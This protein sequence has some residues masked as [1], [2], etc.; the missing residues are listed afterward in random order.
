MLEIDILLEA[1]KAS[2]TYSKI[3]L[4]V[5]KKELEGKRRSMY[6]F[7]WP[8]NLIILEKENEALFRKIKMQTKVRLENFDVYGITKEK[9]DNIKERILRLD[10]KRFNN[11]RNYFVIKRLQN[12]TK[13]QKKRVKV[14]FAVRDTKIDN[15]LEYKIEKKTVSKFQLIEDGEWGFNIG[16]QFWTK[17]PAY[18]GLLIFVELGLF[19]GKRVVIEDRCKI[20]SRVH[21]DKKSISKRFVIREDEVK[22]YNKAAELT[23]QNLRKLVNDSELLKRCKKYHKRYNQVKEGFRDYS[24]KAVSL[25]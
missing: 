20:D 19:K 25:L 24:V 9:Y 7:Y 14:S 22:V 8:K 11:L 3:R 15:S 2:R 21:T 13:E 10:Y 18:Y 6:C 16:K 5:D 4:A 17:I 23:Y 12:L 1:E